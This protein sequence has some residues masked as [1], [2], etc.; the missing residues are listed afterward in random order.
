MI[1]EQQFKR[2]KSSLFPWLNPG[3]SEIIFPKDTFEDL[4]AELGWENINLW[5]EYWQQR[6]CNHIASSCRPNNAKSDWIWG[7]A[8]PF[9][10]DIERYLFQQENK[11]VFGISG[12]PGCGKSCLGRWLEAAANELGWELAVISMDDFYLPALLLDKAMEGNPLNVPRALPGSHSIELL[13]ETIDS[14][15]ENGELFAPKF[16]KSLRNGLGDRCG[17]HLARPKALVIEGWFLG[18]SAVESQKNDISNQSK[19]NY[20]LTNDEKEYRK[21]V[22]ESLK[23]YEPIWKRFKRIW[24]LKASQFQSSSLWK[25]QQEY[26][27]KIERGSSLQGESLKSFIRMIHTAIPERNLQSIDADALAT[28][29]IERK[30]EWIGIKGNN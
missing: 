24:H 15:L 27:M 23:L 29:N 1:E 2:S 11:V 7:L 28:L 5:F 6:E 14:W 21:I 19:S 9:L 25:L 16:D 8:L 17:W 18:C 30:I 22:H 4:L 20:C 3:D 13:Q 26:Q 10:T 12:L